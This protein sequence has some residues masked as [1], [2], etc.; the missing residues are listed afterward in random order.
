[1]RQHGHF[2][3]AGGAAPGTLRLNFGCY[4]QLLT[5]DRTLIGHEVRIMK[6]WL[7]IESF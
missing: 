1:M 4:G 3:D 2:T 5:T 6:V 7:A